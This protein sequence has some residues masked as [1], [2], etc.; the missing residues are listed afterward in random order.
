LRESEARKTAIAESAL[1]AARAKSEFLANMSHEIRTPMTAILGY[2]DLLSDPDAGERERGDHVETI[3]RNGEH[4]QHIINDILDLSK[5]EAGKMALERV[6]CSPVQ[7]VSEVA[8]LMRPRAV[9][10]GLALDVEFH[11][12]LPA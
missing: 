1:E 11:G 2:T 6:A 10:K 5:I 7:L 3:R 4:L 12:P 9:G 8:A